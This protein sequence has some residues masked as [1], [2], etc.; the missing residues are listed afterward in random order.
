MNKGCLG[1]NVVSRRPSFTTRYVLLV[2][3]LLLI[4]NTV[5]GVV[6]LM[7]S[8]EAMAALVDKNM[9]DLVKSASASLDGDV[10]G[11]LTEDDVDGPEF[12]DIEK[13]LLVFQNSTDIQFIYAVKREDDGR[14][15]FTVDPDPV[16]PGA[17]GEEIVTTPALVM[18][19]EGTP[20]V[21]SNPAQ[22]RWGN[23]YSAYSPVFDSSG[24][25]AGMVGVDFD[26]EWYDAQIRKYTVSIAAVT[27]ASVILAGV[28]VVYITRGVR[29]KFESINSGLSE[30]SEGLD[31]LMSEIKTNPDY[32]VSIAQ[33]NEQKDLVK[34]DVSDELGALDTK[35]RILQNEMGL[36]LDY[37]RRRAYIDA[38]TNVSNSISYYETVDAIN[39][40]IERGE[41]DFWVIVFDINGLKELNDTFGH[42]CGDYYIIGAARSL[43]K[44]FGRTCVFRIGGDEFAVISEDL[45]AEYVHD[46]LDVVMAS[47]EEF[48]ASSEYDAVLSVSKGV[49]Y[50]MPGQDTT[51]SDV[52][53]RADKIM[54]ENKRAYYR[55]SGTDGRG[56]RG[57]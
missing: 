14:Y 57:A 24:K 32:E 20:T 38:L 16:D 8:S 50:Y 13:K 52:F 25:V 40:A 2:G 15:V 28:V 41:A 48:N 10:L 56:P 51:F 4:T 19:S 12:R 22:D 27:A 53:A 26:T 54:Y 47:V 30:L 37:L 1:A 43:E 46:G 9:L 31:T 21:D 39:A 49:A 5:L 3:I 44:G 34:D 23:F 45:G 6:V 42:E 17:F 18:A 35:V 55:E 33:A 7:Q 11:N 36:Y 29:R